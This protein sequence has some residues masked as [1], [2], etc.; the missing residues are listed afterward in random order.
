MTATQ[1]I[2]VFTG[3]IANTT[4]QLCNARDLHE[5]LESRREFATWIKDRIDEYDFIEGQDFLTILSKSHGRPKKEY[6]LT[7]EMAKELGMIER[8]SKGKIIRQYF[9][10]CERQAKKAQSSVKSTVEISTD[11]YI[12]LL[13]TQN[14][15]LKQTLSIAKPVHKKAPVPLTAA[16]KQRILTL[17]AQ[18]LSKADIAAQLNRSRSAV[19]AVIRENQGE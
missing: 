16:E 12:E 2:P 18:G 3:Q 1:L 9:I 10:E 6:H 17:H 13:E 14:Q 8:S 5:F 7:L 4:L 11:K 15:L 19:R